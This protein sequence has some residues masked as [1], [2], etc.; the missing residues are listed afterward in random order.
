MLKPYSR[1]YREQKRKRCENVL[2]NSIEDEKRTGRAEVKE[3]R[4]EQRLI[5]RRRER[6]RERREGKEEREKRKES[7][8]R[9]QGAR[10]I[11]GGYMCNKYIC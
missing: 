5:E 9:D 11:T 10:C 2:K 7:Q 4:E 8:D 3:E 1:K 6:E